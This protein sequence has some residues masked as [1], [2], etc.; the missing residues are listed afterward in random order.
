MGVYKGMPIF[1]DA[2]G[3]NRRKVDKWNSTNSLMYAKF[4]TPTDDA[5]NSPSVP[6]TSLHVN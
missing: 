5:T 6:R 1:N 4:A 3:Q 2:L